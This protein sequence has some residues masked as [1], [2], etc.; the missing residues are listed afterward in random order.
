MQ[1]IISNWNSVL[2]NAISF[3]ALNSILENGLKAEAEELLL[4]YLRTQDDSFHNTK[5]LR[6]FESIVNG[7]DHKKLGQIIFFIYT[8]FMKLVHLRPGFFLIRKLIQTSNDEE[9]QINL[10]NQ[11]NNHLEEFVSIVNGS[12]L[13]Q[14]IIRNF[15]LKHKIN[16]QNNLTFSEKVQRNIAKIMDS[17]NSNNRHKKVD[18]SFTEDSEEKESKEE[19][20]DS[21]CSSGLSLFFDILINKVLISS[22]NKHSF[23]ILETA[24]KYGGVCF[25][26]K[27]LEKF[28]SLKTEEVDIPFATCLTKSERGIK[29]IKSAFTFMNAKEK[30]CLHT[31]LYTV[32]IKSNCRMKGIDDLLNEYKLYRK[33]AETCDNYNSSL[34]QIIPAQTQEGNPV[35]MHFNYAN[36]NLPNRK[37]DYNRENA[38]LQNSKFVTSDFGPNPLTQVNNTYR[39]GEGYKPYSCGQYPYCFPNL[40]NSGLSGK[41]VNLF[42]GNSLCFNQSNYPY[43]RFVYNNAQTNLYLVNA[44]SKYENLQSIKPQKTSAQNQNTTY[45]PIQKPLYQ[46]T[47]CV[48]EVN[49]SKEI[50]SQPKSLSTEL[51]SSRFKFAQDRKSS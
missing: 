44:P 7:F 35:K 39:M 45:H 14:S 29:F 21:Y 26:E 15:G 36:P 48:F 37:S 10:I 17:I 43:N 12:L 5:T 46:G 24:L 4:N 34:K 42:G 33:D 40:E 47:S 49:N 23:K 22:L 2:R 30:Y 20:A 6:L 8:N 32:Y 51:G 1:L 28:G 11:I 31:L 13:S 50:E 18:D 41:P 9:I 16:S 3:N 25:H 19:I 38:D 27:V